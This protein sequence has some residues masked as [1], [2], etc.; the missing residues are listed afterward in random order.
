VQEVAGGAAADAAPLP[1]SPI[2]PD[3]VLARVDGDRELL[4]ELAHIFRAQA[5]DL[6]AGLE[7]AVAVGDAK[8]VEHLAHTLR[9]SVANFGAQEAVR[10]AQE[11]ELRGRNGRLDDAA[12]LVV[13]LDVETAGIDRALA[14]LSGV[15]QP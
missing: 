4:I 11:L 3:D 6:M 12:D 2:D 9:G 15:P 8:R 10:I 1:D 5:R 7:A 14:E 13:R